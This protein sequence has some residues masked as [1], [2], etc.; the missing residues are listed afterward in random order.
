[1]SKKKEGK[2]FLNLQL[3]LVVPKFDY[4]HG[5]FLYPFTA[6]VNRYTDGRPDHW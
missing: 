6:L 3:Q 2:V 1:M 5:N 4:Q